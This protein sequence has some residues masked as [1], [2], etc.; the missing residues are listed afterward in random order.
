MIKGTLITCVC[1]FDLGAPRL[2]S[3]S[4]YSRAFF[5]R[6][7]VVGTSYG[8]SLSSSAQQEV[9]TV[10][11]INPLSITDQ[12]QLS[13]VSEDY[14]RYLLS[15]SP[16]ELPFAKLWTGGWCPLGYG[17]P[18]PLGPSDTSR[19]ACIKCSGGGTCAVCDPFYSCSICVPGYQLDPE[20][21]CQ[22]KLY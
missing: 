4:R 11:S 14:W 13:S 3:H 2:S 19:T 6:M 8:R 15:V 1:D 7:L 16:N 22:K 21:V 20:G 9:A 17:N 18:A 10:G 12:S 5:A